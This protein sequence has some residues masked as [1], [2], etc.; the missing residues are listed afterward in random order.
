[1]RLYLIAY[2]MSRDKLVMDKRATLTWLHVRNVTP[3][4]SWMD[5]KT[6]CIERKKRRKDSYVWNDDEV[7]LLVMVTI[8]VLSE[9][10][11]SQCTGQLYVQGEG[12]HIKQTKNLN[13]IKE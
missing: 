1:M 10:I 9:K 13:F 6:M 4:D 3:N 7:E 12:I 8:W 5:V 2:L 11:L